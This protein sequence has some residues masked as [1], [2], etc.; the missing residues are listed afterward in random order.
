VGKK[1]ALSKKKRTTRKK[2][3]MMEID[4]EGHAL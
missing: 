1:T 2:R 3:Q 4:D